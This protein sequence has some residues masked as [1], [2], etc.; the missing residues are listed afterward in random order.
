VNEKFKRT[1]FEERFKGILVLLFFGL[2]LA[3]CAEH[4]KEH[5]IRNLINDGKLKDA[6]SQVDVFLNQNPDEY[7]L[8]LLKGEIE[9]LRNN[10][11]EASYNFITYNSKNPANP[12][13][14]ELLGISELKRGNKEGALN[15]FENSYELE[16]TK[17]RLINVLSIIVELGKDERL[18]QYSEKLD[19]LMVHEQLTRKD[20]LTIA[21]FL[22]VSNRP[23][24]AID[25]YSAIE[26]ESLNEIDLAKYA[27]ALQMLDRNYGAL[28]LSEHAID[29]FPNSSQFLN[30]RTHLLIKENLADSL[31]IESCR[32]SIEI[33]TAYANQA[34]QQLAYIFMVNEDPKCCEIADSLDVH[35]ITYSSELRSY[36]TS[37]K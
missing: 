25:I 11:S 17:D 28:Q 32:K 23:Q 4:H 20:S 33:Y 24:D 7:D 34:Y 21:N 35:Y 5:Q 36:C 31:I 10:Y 22:T 9:L 19:A 30:L 8:Y 6:S 14:W 12:K 15:S 1:R 13:A 29:V 3:T 37:I 18:S 27:L 2:V 26:L 16:S